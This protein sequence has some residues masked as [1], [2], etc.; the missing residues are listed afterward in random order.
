MTHGHRSPLQHRR[1]AWFWTG[2][3]LALAAGCAPEPLDSDKPVETESELYLRN[4]RAWTEN[5]N[6][7]PVC[8]TTTGYTTEKQVIRDAVTNTWQAESS[9]SFSWTDAC[10]TTGSTR[11]VK[12][13]ITAQAKDAN[14]NYPNQGGD[15]SSTVGMDDSFRL[16]GDGPGMTLAFR[17][18]HLVTNGRNQYIGVHEMGHTLGFFH[19]QDRPENEGGVFCSSG[20][21]TDTTGLIEGSYDQ[22]SIMNYC[23]SGGNANG[24]I[25]SWDKLGVAQ[26]YARPGSQVAGTTSDGRLWHAFRNSTLT[27]SGFGDP[28]Q[29]AGDIG[30]VSDVAMQYLKKGQTHVL[31]VNTAGGLFHTIRAANGTWGGF[32]DVKGAAGNVGS[33]TRVA[34]AEIN[35]E[36]HVAGITS[37]NHLWHTIRHVNGSWNSFVDIETLAGDRGNF[38]NIG[39]TGILGELQA[40]GV[41]S[42]GHIYHALRQASGTWTGFGD[43]E[44]AIGGDIGTVVDA[45]CTAVSGKLQL[46]AVNSSGQVWHTIRSADGSWIPWG[47]VL[48]AASNPGAASTVALSQWRGELQVTINVSGTPY[49]AIR[50]TDGSWTT[51]GNI[52]TQAGNV[53]TFTSIAMD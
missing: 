51:F 50:H 32:G 53:G 22:D 33:F 36:V 52:K 2:G 3:I 23:N 1:R 11:Y 39:I 18:D 43:I 24:V 6:V 41:T 30:S 28:E 4:V 13:Q 7:V 38:V 12:I 47:N 31:A 9:L 26:V 46:V 45:D 35:D 10:P 21:A 34:A 29:F 16:P 40:C 14:G 42:D 20:V 48:L 44:A 27:W 37:N 15:G 19:E 8:W 49:N 17:P 25:S 5:N